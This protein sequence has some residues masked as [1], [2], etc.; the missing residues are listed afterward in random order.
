MQDGVSSRR[1]AATDRSI[2]HE[3]VSGKT[4]SQRTFMTVVLQMADSGSGVHRIAIKSIRRGYWFVIN[5]IALV[6]TRG[7]ISV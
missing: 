7:P 4:Q 6:K 1:C 5:G 3:Q 2:K